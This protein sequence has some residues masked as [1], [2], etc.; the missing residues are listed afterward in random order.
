MALLQ[1]LV[2]PDCIAQRL[3]SSELPA[4]VMLA[5]AMI[6]SPSHQPC[7]PHDLFLCLQK[8]EELCGGDSAAAGEETERAQH[9]PGRGEADAH[10]AER[11]G[12]CTRLLLGF[13]I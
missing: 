13:N 7:A 6:S 1:I 2:N 4:Y 9:D 3:E 12:I 8:G 11:P 5:E 10:R